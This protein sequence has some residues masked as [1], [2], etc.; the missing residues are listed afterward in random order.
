[1]ERGDGYQN[2]LLGKTAFYDFAEWMGRETYNEEHEVYESDNVDRDNDGKITG[3]LFDFRDSIADEVKQGKIDNFIHNWFGATEDVNA[4]RWEGYG[5]EIGE[6]GS[7]Q[8][9]TG[10]TG[11]FCKIGEDD[12][13]HDILEYVTPTE[14]F[15]PTTNRAYAWDKKWDRNDIQI[16][17]A[18]GGDTVGY[19]KQFNRQTGWNALHN[20]ISGESVINMNTTVPFHRNYAAAQ[21]DGISANAVVAGSDFNQN[22]VV[23]ALGMFTKNGQYMDMLQ[24]M[25][26]CGEARIAG[27]E[28]K[29]DKADYALRM[30]ELE[31]EKVAEQRAEQRRLASIRQALRGKKKSSSSQQTSTRSNR[32]SNEHYQGSPEYAKAMQKLRMRILK[33]SASRKAMLQKTKEDTK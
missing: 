21:L 4:P 9:V 26:K 1:M 30:E 22:W 2:S 8:S 25:Q 19:V 31:D 3:K 18:G 20:M 12:E 23:H 7:W 14:A 24:V 29:Q 11:I 16:H 28:F 10:L 15:I 27:N 32:S 17:Y 5:D 13:G 33:P 6:D